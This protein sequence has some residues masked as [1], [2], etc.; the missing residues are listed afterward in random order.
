MV[1]GLGGKQNSAPSAPTFGRVLS[2]RAEARLRPTFRLCQPRVGTTLLRA[3]LICR[4]TSRRM[5]GCVTT[6]L[7]CRICGRGDAEESTQHIAFCENVQIVGQQLFNLQRAGKRR[8]GSTTF[9]GSYAW[10]PS[11][12]MANFGGV[13]SSF[14]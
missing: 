13:H 4:A 10:S 14:R 8:A 9:R 7:S 5:R 3:W 12:E 6:T 11:A 1:A 2:E